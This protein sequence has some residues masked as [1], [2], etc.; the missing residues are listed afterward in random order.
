MPP[1]PRSRRSPAKVD[2]EKLKEMFE[3]WKATKEGTGSI[4]NRG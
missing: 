4:I 3:Q 2:P 1:K